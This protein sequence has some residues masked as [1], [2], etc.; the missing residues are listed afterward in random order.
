MGRTP[1]FEKVEHGIMKGLEKLQKWYMA[2]DQSDMFFI[3]LGKLKH[4][5]GVILLL[6]SSLALEPTIKVEYAK[7]K[8]DEF[9]YNQGMAALKA[10]V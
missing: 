9:S 5:F 2:T 7:Q 8:W 10:K 1:K 3:C 4:I 6:I